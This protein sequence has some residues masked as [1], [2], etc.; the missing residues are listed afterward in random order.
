MASGAFEC[1][2]LPRTAIRAASLVE[3][4]AVDFK[5]RLLQAIENDAAGADTDVATLLR[6]CK[7]LAARLGNREFQLGWIW[8]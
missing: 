6:K 3:L 7:I 5:M 4:Q 2:H 1:A 8:N